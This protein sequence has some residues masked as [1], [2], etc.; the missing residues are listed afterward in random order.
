MG[1]GKVHSKVRSVS[2]QLIDII[3]SQ[4]LHYTSHKH[5]STLVVSIIDNH[6]HTV[7]DCKSLS[8]SRYKYLH[9]PH[10]PINW[11]Y[12]VQLHTQTAP[13]VDQ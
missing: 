12:T 5:T 7:T 8:L 4:H 10:S 11:P 2:K 3:F 1:G 13:I 6:I 9:N